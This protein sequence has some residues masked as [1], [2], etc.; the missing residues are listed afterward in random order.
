[1]AFQIFANKEGHVT[2]SELGFAFEWSP[3]YSHRADYARLVRD[4]LSYCVTYLTWQAVDYHLEGH[5][6]AP[7]AA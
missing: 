4:E 5:F 2:V 7:V 6:V 3:M 1:M